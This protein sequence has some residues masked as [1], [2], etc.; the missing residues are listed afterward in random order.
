M[1]RRE[2]F[3]HYVKTGFTEPGAEK[4]VICSPQI[5]ANAGYDA[6]LAGKI[7]TGEATFSDTMAAVSRYD[8]LPLYNVWIGSLAHYDP[9]VTDVST[10]TDTMKEYSSHCDTPYGTMYR[11]GFEYPYK[12]GGTL[13]YAVNS[14]EDLDKLEYILDMAM[15]EGDFSH[16]T[17]IARDYS[18]FFGDDGPVSLQWEMAP[19]AMLSYPSIATTAML[20]YDDEKRYYRLMDKIEALDMRIIDAIV[21]TGI[22]FIVLGSHG[23]EIISPRYYDDYIMPYAIRL[24]DYAHEKGFMIYN[25]SCGLIEPMLTMGYFN[26]MGIDLFETI[27]PQPEGN[28]ITF[29]DA[30]SK[31]DPDICT[32]G[33]VSLTLLLNGSPEDVKKEVFSIMKAAEG[34]KHFVAASDY[35]M[36]D[37]PE[38]NVIAMCEAVEE[39]YK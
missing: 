6:K 2:K 10:R 15:S 12:G 30:L 21:G 18:A 35:L 31:L 38:A 16:Y 27:S 22:D 26:R 23:S 14:V 32:R 36:Y 13:V 28:I 4:R 17:K 9:W 8:M 20:P 3:L 7:Y 24:A 39:Y 33:N 1:T 37:V 34:R 5:G 25:H 19:Y 11:H 29:E